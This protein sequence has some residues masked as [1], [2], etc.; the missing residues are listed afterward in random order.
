MFA[1]PRQPAL[2]KLASKLLRIPASTAQLE[3]LFSNWSYVHNPVRNR[4][5]GE[6][7][8]KIVHVYYSL[9]NEDKNKIDEY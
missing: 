6:R 4:L 9:K 8:K 3:R 2:S 1:E 7:S 5:T